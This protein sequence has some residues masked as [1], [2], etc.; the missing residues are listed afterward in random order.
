MSVG[1]RGQRGQV[2]GDRKAAFNRQ[3]HLSFTELM[4]FYTVACDII[5]FATCDR[6]VRCLR[7]I[8]AP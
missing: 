5:S 6:M 3:S 1:M 4:A 7:F 2:K 8:V